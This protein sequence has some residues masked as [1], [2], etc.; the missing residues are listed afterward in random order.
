MS[1][2]RFYF[3]NLQH[4]DMQNKYFWYIGCG[5]LNWSCLGCL[6][7]YQWH[8]VKASKACFADHTLSS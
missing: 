8:V 4:D 1:T 5:S 2:E 6:Q 7:V 3:R